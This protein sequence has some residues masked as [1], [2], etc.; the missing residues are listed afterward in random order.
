M[1]GCGEYA[2][3]LDVRAMKVEPRRKRVASGGSVGER[4]E[5]L[6]KCVRAGSRRVEAVEKGSRLCLRVVVEMGEAK[7]VWK[8]REEPD[9][10]NR[11]DHEAS[12]RAKTEGGGGS[13]AREEA[14]WLAWFAGVARVSTSEREREREREKERI[15]V[16]E[17]RGGGDEEAT[18]RRGRDARRSLQASF[19]ERR[20]GGAQSPSP[21]G[22]QR[23]AAH[24]TLSP[25]THTHRHPTH[26][27]I[28]PSRPTRLASTRFERGTNPHTHANAGKRPNSPTA[29]L[30]I[31]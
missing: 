1:R 31:P 9:E 18:R 8:L 20:S 10:C 14:K 29:K 4:R 30:G 2:A 6:M 23:R 28:S 22:V 21:G 11:Y 3:T 12:E 13:R 7:G 19:A 5:G 15:R 26:P 16:G 25:F 27:Q 17:R 24:P